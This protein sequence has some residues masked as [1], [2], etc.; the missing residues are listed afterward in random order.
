MA[1]SGWMVLYLFE[2]AFGNG[3][4]MNLG[5][6]TGEVIGVGNE[7]HGLLESIYESYYDEQ[8]Q[9]VDWG[10]SFQEEYVPGWQRGRLRNAGRV[11]A[12]FGSKHATV[13]GIG[14]K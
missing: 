1:T 11:E 7:K 8:T 13:G 14:W 2:L 3:S 4:D 10:S 5:S 6:E 12:G 9:T